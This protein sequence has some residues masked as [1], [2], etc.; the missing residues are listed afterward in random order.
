MIPA[1]TLTIYDKWGRTPCRRWVD[2]CGIPSVQFFALWGS[3]ILVP[4]VPD[5]LTRLGLGSCRLWLC[6]AARSTNRSTW[7]LGVLIPSPPRRRTRKNDQFSREAIQKWNQLKTKHM[8][9]RL[10]ACGLSKEDIISLLRARNRHV[11][12]FCGVRLFLA[13]WAGWLFDSISTTPQLQ[14]ALRLFHLGTLGSSRLNG[15]SLFQVLTQVQLRV[16]L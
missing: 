4:G 7:R 14:L 13:F 9:A 11:S 10:E 8:F 6:S 3:T 2:G 16:R 1:R 5:F 12:F 15:L